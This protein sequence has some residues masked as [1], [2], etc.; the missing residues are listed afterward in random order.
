MDDKIKFLSEKM[1]KEYVLNDRRRTGSEDPVDILI[2]SY[3]SALKLFDVNAEESIATGTLNFYMEHVDKALDIFTKGMGN[4]KAATTLLFAFVKVQELINEGEDGLREKF[5]SELINN[6]DYY[7]FFS[8]DYYLE[9]S[10]TDGLEAALKEL[11]EDVNI[12]ATTYY[13]AAYKEYLDILP[14]FDELM[15]ILSGE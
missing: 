1:S 8:L 12:R 4:L 15:R 6:K 3:S 14:G 5:S 7:S 11:E 10:R 13:N 9:L 2:S